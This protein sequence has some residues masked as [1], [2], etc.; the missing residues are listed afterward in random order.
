MSPSKPTPWS[1]FLVS[2][3]VT[4]ILLLAGC[5]SASGPP[6]IASASTP[7]AP[8]SAS[9]VAASSAPPSAPGRTPAGTPVDVAGVPTAPAR[10]TRKPAHPAPD[11]ELKDVDGKTWK[12]SALRGKGVILS[13]WFIG[14]PPCRA[15]APYL[16]ELAE[17]YRDK[18]LVVLAVD[19]RPEESRDDVSD[20][21]ATENVKHV[22]LPQGNAVA[23]KYGVN[24]TPT[25]FF[26]DPDGEIYSNHRGFDPVLGIGQLE[27][28]ARA[29]LPK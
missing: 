15:E 24:R 14:C 1:R 12:L 21:R 23:T 11:F 19:V 13:F 2:T 18:G 10:A 26:I 28:P 5:D 9:S 6:A 16:S 3:C 17:R 7:S 20:F 22:L 25:T 27:L 4:A 29:V 8:T